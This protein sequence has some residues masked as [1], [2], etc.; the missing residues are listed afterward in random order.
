MTFKINTKINTERNSPSKT[1]TTIICIIS[2]ALLCGCNKGGISS[3]KTSDTDKNESVSSNQNDTNSFINI[4]EEEITVSGLTEDHSFYFIA[5]SHISL[6]DERDKDVM[7]KAALRAMG[8]KYEEMESWDTFSAIMDKSLEKNS[9][10]VILGGDIIDSAMYAS[11]DFVKGQLKKLDDNYIYFMGNHDFEYG[12]EYFSETAYSEYLPRLS[13]IHGNKPYQ[14]KDMGEYIIFA[15]DDSNSQI[16]AESLEAFKQTATENKPIILS[17]HVPIE[18]LTGD[19]SLTEACIE[20]WGA[21]QSGGSKVTMGVNGC[22]PN[23][24]TQEFISAALSEDS[25]VV[26]VLAGHIHFYH[27]DMLNDKIPQIVTGA[28]F[29]GE[30]LYITLKAE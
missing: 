3:P 1:L 7:E 6:C 9:E 10:I 25:P 16:D 2:L 23:E 30:G 20:K 8:F 13:D 19:N 14:I 18:P 4:R 26:L 27:K 22:Y 29:E 21:S 11:I 15:V 5:D 24:I 28:A 12:T 17:L